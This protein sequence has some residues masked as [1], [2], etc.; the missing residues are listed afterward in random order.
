MAYRVFA[1]HAHVFP[2]S[3]NSN[4]TIDRL[5]QLLDACEIDG[6]VC[7]APF[8]HQCEGKDI[9]DPN[10]WLAAEL[11]KHSRLVGFGTIDPRRSDCREQVWQAAHWYTCALLFSS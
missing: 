3:I 6:A 8:S 11:K 4:G 10:K 9:P 7:F 5:L 1:N 2:A